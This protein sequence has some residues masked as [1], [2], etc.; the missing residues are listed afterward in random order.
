MSFQAA[1]DR[2]DAI[3]RTRVKR[4]AG[5]GQSF[6]IDQEAARKS[7][8]QP[9]DFCTGQTFSVSKVIGYGPMFLSE[10]Y[11][12]VLPLSSVRFSAG[13]DRLPGLYREQ[14]GFRDRRR[15]DIKSNSNVCRDRTRGQGKVSFGP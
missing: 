5:K 8:P 3:Y 1:G 12:F 10:T 2:G 13:G 4:T 15:F 7:E 14:E 9:L 11:A 6:K